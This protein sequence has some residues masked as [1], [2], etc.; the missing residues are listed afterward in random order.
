V[1]H[2]LFEIFNGTLLHTCICSFLCIN[3][4]VLGLLGAKIS[5]LV[6]VPMKNISTTSLRMIIMNHD[7]FLHM[8]KWQMNVSAP[9]LIGTKIYE[10]VGGSKEIL[11]KAQSQK[12]CPI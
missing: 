5:E 11:L 4:S 3:F 1:D 12:V 9:S 7:F 8:L 2:E 10:L 6:G